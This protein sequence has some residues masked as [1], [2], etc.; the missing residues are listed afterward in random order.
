MYK[1]SWFFSICLL[2]DLGVI[3]IYFSLYELF[4]YLFLL[5]VFTVIKF[6]V[7]QCLVH[8]YGFTISLSYLTFFTVPNI[9][10]SLH[11]CVM[12]LLCSNPCLGYILYWM[13]DIFQISRVWLFR[14]FI[15]NE[16]DY[17]FFRMLYDVLFVFYICVWSLLG[18]SLLE[19][20][21]VRIK[22]AAVYS[23]ILDEKKFSLPHIFI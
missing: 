5:A 8:F 1:F 17:W 11:D 22:M 14:V 4:F 23:F 16:S 6:I 19:A 13:L 2:Y 18:S 9:F 20:L 10:Q 7:I 21:R 12:C 3:L 15:C